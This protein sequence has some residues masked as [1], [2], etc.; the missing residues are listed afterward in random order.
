MV[1]N[2]MVSTYTLVNEILTEADRNYLAKEKLINRSTNPTWIKLDGKTR[3][4]ISQNDSYEIVYETVVEEAPT[5]NNIAR[6]QSLNEFLLKNEN[7]FLN[8]F[9]NLSDRIDKRTGTLRKTCSLLN[10]VNINS[11]MIFQ[12]KKSIANLFQYENAYSIT[13]GFGTNTATISLATWE[14]YTEAYANLNRLDT[15][16]LLSDI[17]TITEREGDQVVNKFNSGYVKAIITDIIDLVSKT[18]YNY[19]ITKS[20]DVD[21]RNEYAKAKDGRTKHY[22]KYDADNQQYV[23]VET[24]NEALELLDNHQLYERGMANQ[25]PIFK[26]KL[27]EKVPSAFEGRNPRLVKVY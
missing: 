10:S 23:E 3:T 15:V 6:A 18:E 5:Y 22:Y 17:T 19:S 8:S 7:L 24:L 14:P 21:I 11:Q 25:G 4:T 1:S 20:N 13:G 9:F 27:N 12:K 16:Y 2:N 26:V